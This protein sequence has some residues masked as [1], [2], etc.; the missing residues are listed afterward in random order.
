MKMT[1]CKYVF[2]ALLHIGVVF[3]CIF[4]ATGISSDKKVPKTAGGF[5]L[6]TSIS[7]YEFISYDNFVKE[8]VVTDIKGFRKGS[9]TYG[10]CD[11]PGEI[12]RIK[13]K[14]HDKSYKFF[15]EL[16]ERYKKKLGK[17]P[18]YIGD[19]FGIVKSW[20]WEYKD[21][22]GQRVTVVLQHNLKNI[23]ETMGNMVK[24][25]LPDQINAE[26]ECYNKL[27]KFRE[28]DN[29]N[30]PGKIDWQLLLPE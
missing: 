15:K 25:T 17:N 26:R 19:S 6:G 3:L 28:N 22:N 11:K 4:P 1:S 7:D 24:L 21:K 13:L 27:C 5:T 12:V 23:D 14:Y 8:V 9:V 16:L 18:L 30:A 2:T 20:K 29:S 10:V